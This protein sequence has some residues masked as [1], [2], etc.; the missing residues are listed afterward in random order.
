M[1]KALVLGGGGYD[2]LLEVVDEVVYDSYY[3]HGLYRD[4]AS[5]DLIQFTGGSDVSPVLYN[6]VALPTTHSHWE[7]DA[8]EAAVY[9]KA[10]ALGIPMVGVCRGLQFLHVMNGGTLYQHKENH[11]TPHSIRASNSP[12]KMMADGRGTEPY[13][14]RLLSVNSIHHQLCR[15]NLDMVVLAT[16]S[17]CS[18]PP[19]LEIEAAYYLKTRCFGVQFHP[20]FMH[21]EAPGLKWYIENVKEL[22]KEVKT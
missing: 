22:L 11:G 20:E 6:E 9:E 8:S 4:L 13:D 10:R 15:H 16:S 14:D 2:F 12:L 7:R 19:F 5:Y 3:R 1:S 17:V 18:D 21:S